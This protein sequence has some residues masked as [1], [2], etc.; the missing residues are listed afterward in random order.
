MF[1]AMDIRLKSNLVKSSGVRAADIQPALNH[2]DQNMVDSDDQGGMLEHDQVIGEQRDAGLQVEDLNHEDNIVET[3]REGQ[4]E[5]LEVNI[6]DEQCTDL[7]NGPNTLFGARYGD[8]PVIVE[9]FKDKSKM[10]GEEVVEGNF[11]I[12]DE[13]IVHDIAVKDE[14]K[15]DVSP[16]NVVEE[17][18]LVPKAVEYIVD[19]DSD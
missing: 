6:N 5:G 3:A 13:N 15:P 7:I 14:L 11:V 1:P 16:T 2:K 17:A 10:D 9:K 18:A 4:P 12:R 8:S 19:C